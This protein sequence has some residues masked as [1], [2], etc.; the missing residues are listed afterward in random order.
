MGL[1]AGAALR[2]AATIRTMQ[3]QQLHAFTQHMSAFRLSKA[4]P[5]FPSSGHLVFEMI[6]FST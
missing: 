2:S 5:F 1:V 6:Y 3:K 4:K